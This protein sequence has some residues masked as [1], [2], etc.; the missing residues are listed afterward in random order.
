MELKNRNDTVEIKTKNSSEDDIAQ[1]RKYIDSVWYLEKLSPRRNEDFFI[2]IKKLPFYIGRNVDCELILPF[3]YISRYHAQVINEGSF[4]R[5]FDLDSVNGVYVN[6][7]KIKKSVLLKDGDILHFSKLFDT[8]ISFKVISKDSL[9][10][11]AFRSRSYLPE[12]KQEKKIVIDSLIK[13]AQLLESKECSFTVGR[14]L[15]L[16]VQ[17]KKK[18]FIKT[19]IF[20]WKK[21][22]SLTVDAA[23]I[24]GL[25]I[26]EG[27]L[28]TARFFCDN[29]VFG[30]STK[31]RKIELSPTLRL[32]LMYP[33]RITYISYRRNTRYKTNLKAK[34]RKY[35]KDDN[36]KC[37]VIDISLHGLRVSFPGD[38][39]T[40][41]EGEI[42]L[43]LVDLINDIRVQK[44]HEKT[45]NS[46]FQVG[47]KILSFGGLAKKKKYEEILDF[48]APLGEF[49]C[50]DG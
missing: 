44:V 31:I 13:R 14:I 15:S 23:E 32:T 21:G 18:D 17:D 8:H 11:E 16:E 48:H 41:L 38:V 43:T 30:F 9:K 29:K 36:I 28:C 34:I 3:K 42:L 26:K 7:K 24:E 10:N 40:G 19:Q 50:D 5:I 25:T 49:V 33:K 4:L 27:T 37:T 47:F 12:D 22:I 2:Q 35:P 45:T 6:Q 46:D 20:S 1:I 39:R